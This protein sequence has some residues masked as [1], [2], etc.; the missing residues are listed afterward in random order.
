MSFGG[1]PDIPE[2]QPAPPAAPVRVLPDVQKAKSDLIEK[3]R[4]ARSRQ[5][6]RK[7]I[8]GLLDL[9]APTARPVLN[10]LL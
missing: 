9:A 2:V 7:T 3:L 4:R 1:S 6:S 8:P 10:D 5:K